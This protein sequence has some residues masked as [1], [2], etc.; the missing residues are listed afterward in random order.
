MAQSPVT[1]TAVPDSHAAPVHLNIDDFDSLLQKEF[2]PRSES[3]SQAV[4]QAVN[5]LVENVLEYSDA[6]TFGADR[7][8]KELIRELD[9]KL[10]AQINEILHHEE[11]QAVESVWRG[12]DYLVSNTETDVDLRIKVMNVTKN[13]LRNNLKKFK[14][15]AWDQSP[16]FK[17]VYEQEFGQLGG[18]P[19]GV[20][21]GDYYFG[22]SA[23]D[24]ELLAS[25]SKVSAAAHA[26]FISSVS[27]AVVGMDS[28][29]EM[30]NP[31]DLANIFSTPDFAPWR[32]LRESEDSRYVSL[33]LP[34]FM[35]RLPY[36]EDTDPVENMNF[37]EETFGLSTNYTWAN[38]AYAAGVNIGK[39]FKE[40]G[41]CSRIRGVESGGAVGNLP[42][43]TFSTD[44]GG[45]DIKCPTEVAISDRRENE[46]S[47]SGFMPLIYRKN[48]D[49]AAF[50]GA[51]TLHKP[52]IY[53]NPEATANAALAARLPYI[54]ATCRFAHYLKCIARDKIG[55]FKS[56]SEMER[57]LETWIMNYVDGSPDTSSEEVKSRKPL[58][59]AKVEIRA[60]EGAPG[61]YA[62]KFWLRPHFQLEGLTVSLRL[63]SRLPAAD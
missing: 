21:L 39:A 45:V 6:I 35:A 29:R 25:I 12:L 2:K 32:S 52:G 61:Y 49:V 50:I 63:V 43:H 53:D 60:V 46:L 37:E 16:L 41:W 30:S 8:V 23:K 28:W 14:G 20:L 1:E 51:Q 62:A 33:T 59:D 24:V 17:R 55:A 15:A 48:S 3:A 38:A 58:A 27:P 44:D 26:P 36:G 42:C 47:K 5:T 4:S 34:R 54:F 57:W 31:R 40:Y 11:F 9:K 7:T 18:E 22:S 13:D 19:Y 10:S 56:E